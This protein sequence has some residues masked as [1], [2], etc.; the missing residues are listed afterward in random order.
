MSDAVATHP[1]TLTLLSR[2]SKSIYRKT[3]EQLLGMTQRHYLVLSYLAERDQVPQQY[4]QELLWIDANNLVILLNELESLGYAQRL[5]DPEDRRRHIVVL[6]DPGRT[7]YKKAEKARET[8]EDEVLQAL[9]PDEREALRRL[10]V[11][12][13]DG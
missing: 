11:K 3:P 2:L 10:L 13:L 5:R 8:V 12:A 9:D 7:A 6:T 4:L 1:G